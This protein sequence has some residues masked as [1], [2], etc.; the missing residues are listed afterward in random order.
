MSF[1]YDNTTMVD[2]VFLSISDDEIRLG[3]YLWKK[4]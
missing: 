4:R 1:K 2:K 3:E